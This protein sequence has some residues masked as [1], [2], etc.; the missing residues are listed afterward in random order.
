MFFP[1]E[2]QF[3]GDFS[4]QCL[5]TR[6]QHLFFFPMVYGWQRWLRCLKCQSLWVQASWR[7]CG[8]VM[9]TLGC[10]LDDHSWFGFEWRRALT[11]SSGMQHGD[12]NLQLLNRPWSRLANIWLASIWG[13]DDYR[14]SVRS[15]HRGLPQKFFTRQ[16][17][18]E[19]L[20]RVET[21]LSLKR[22]GC[23]FRGLQPDTWDTSQH[24]LD[25]WVCAKVC[26]P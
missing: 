9:T 14:T 21:T 17:K 2:A 20:D 7:T 24:G 22:Q 18:P 3:T 13:G 10:G 6:G 4:L 26:A 1:Y 25:Q 15:F 12:G 5:I 11:K 16:Q 23:F 19:R 8:I